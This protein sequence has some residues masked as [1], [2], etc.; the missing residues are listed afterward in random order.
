MKR[1]NLLFFGML[2]GMGCISSLKAQE[3]TCGFDHQHE[4]FEKANPKAKMSNQELLKRVGKTKNQRFNQ[5]GQYVI[6]VV[7][8]VFGEPTNHESLKVTYDLINNALRQTS[9]DFQGLTA[10]Y[11]QSGPESR[12]EQ[13]KK[14]I[15]IDFRLAKIDPN[16]TPTKGVIFYDEAMK[17]FG[18]GTGYDEIIQK[19]AWD[20][21]K[22]MNIYIMNDLYNDADLYNSGVSWLPNNWMT[23]NN[24]A[25]VVY[26]GSYIGSN[27]NENFRRVL[28]HEFGHFFGLP[29]TFQGGCT[30]PND[31]IEDTPPVEKPQWPANTLNCEGKYTDWENFMNYTDAY[32]HFTKGQVDEMVMHLNESMSRWLLWQDDNLVSTGVNN[33]FTQSPCILV[34]KGRYFTEDMYNN[35]KLDGTVALEAAGGMTFAKVGILSE[36]T[37]YT[38]GNLPQGITAKVTSLSPTEATI[39]LEGEAVNHEQHDGI[40]DITLTLKPSVLQSS[41]NTPAAQHIHF[42]IS[43]M[44]PYTAYCNFNPRYAP[45]AHISKVKFAQIEKNTEFDNYQFKDFRKD[46]VAGLEKGKTYQ[47]NVKVENWKSGQYDPYTVRAWFDWNGDYIF[48]PEEMIAPKYIMRIG[49]PGTTHDL[50]LDVTVPDNF[51][52][53]K[54]VGFRVMLHYTLNND[55]EDPCGVIDSGDVED[56]GMILGEEN[57]HVLPPDDVII[58]QDQ[59][60]IPDFSYRPYA[61][62]EKVEFANIINS[63]PAT[64]DNMVMVEDFTQNEDLIIK[65]E[66]GKTYNMK[67]SCRNIDSGKDDSY[68]VRSYIDW[69][70]NNVLEKSETQK[71]FIHKAGANN[72]LSTVEFNWTVPENAIINEKTHVRVYLHFGGEN[73]FA[74]ENPC[75]DVENGQI[76]EYKAV[77]AAPPSGTESNLSDRISLYP[78][79]TEGIIYLQGGDFE[80]C[81]YSLY[82]IS[83]Q[84]IKEGIIIDSQINL[85]KQPRGMYILKI[86]MDDTVVQ[87]SVVLK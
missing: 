47:L 31:G 40:E 18:N 49:K 69:N 79:P 53:G 37:D 63:T 81:T 50:S 3:H 9:E 30:Y 66:K 36:G 2:L 15:N 75:G 16:G 77:V 71:A 28:S 51:V 1:R 72:T 42:G 11:N 48:Q 55:G 57:A 59:V 73:S 39:K 70:R 38:V 85:S 86:Q 17:G 83:G 20:N 45:C 67:V 5:E 35:G 44:D 33:G 52:A 10:D 56:Y 68:T 87:K 4:S 62:I 23:S 7:F 25:R 21:S 82:S 14:P 78:N 74:G 80:M 27:T 8:H 6:P 41:Q 34:S 61:Y 58:P 22:Y 24:L 19:Y 43:F 13:I 60:C 54:E 12:F 26:N 32:R 46:Y 29:H 84:I 65:L 64:L 76:E